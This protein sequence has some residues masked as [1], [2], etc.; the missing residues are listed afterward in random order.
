MLKHIVMFKRKPEVS[1]A[2]FDEVL[3]RFEFLADEISEISSWWFRIP[4]EPTAPYQAGFVSEFKDEAALEAY[5]I[6][7]AHQKL[8]S[9]A[10]TVA[11]AAVFDAWD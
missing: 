9:A 2:E 1:K 10:G 11:T 7:P 6:H 4:Q 5:Q 8:A 3:A